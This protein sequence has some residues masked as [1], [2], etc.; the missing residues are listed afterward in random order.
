MRLNYPF[1]VLNR[2]FAALISCVCIFVPL[3]GWSDTVSQPNIIVIICDDLNDSVAGMGGH[4]LAVTPNIQRLI[5]SGV[6]FT[7][8]ASN[9]PVCGP[10]RASVWSGV[11]PINSGIYGADQH[12]NKWYENEYLVN[13]PTLFRHFIDEGYYVRATGKIHHNGHENPYEV[14][15]GYGIGFGSMVNLDDSYGYQKTI[16]IESFTDTNGNGNWDNGEEYTDA[17]G[18]G[19]YDREVYYDGADFGPY[20]HDG[21]ASTP[22]NKGSVPPWWDHPAEADASK[23][24]GVFG[25]YRDLSAYGSNWKWQSPHGQEFTYIDAVDRNTLPYE[26]LLPDE[27]YAHHAVEFIEDYEKVDSNGDHMPFFLTVGFVRPHTPTWAPKK[28]FDMFSI[29]DIRNTLPFDP[30]YNDYDDITGPVNPSTK[31]LDAGTGWYKYNNF[32]SMSEAMGDD[33]MQKIYENIQA[34]LACVAFVD[35]QVGKVLDAVE[36][37]TDPNIKDNTYIIFTSDHG[38]HFGEKEYIFKRTM[39]EESVR[40]PFVVSGPDVVNYTSTRPISLV[41][42][43]PTCVDLAGINNPN[44]TLDGH[45]IKPLLEDSNGTWEGKD[46]SVSAIASTELPEVGTIADYTK[47]HFSIRSDQYRYIRYRD[48]E[49]ELYNHAVDSPERDNVANES[50]HPLLYA[51]NFSQLQT[52]RDYYSVAVGEGFSLVNP[53]KNSNFYFN[54]PI[55]ISTAVLQGISIDHVDFKIGTTLI[56]RDTE[57]P[58]TTTLYDLSSGNYTI[59]AVS[60]NTDYF[61]SSNISVLDPYSNVEMLVDGDFESYSAGSISHTDLEDFSNMGTANLSIVSGDAQSGS[62]YLNVSGRQHAY[63]SIKNLLRGL[64]NGKEYIISVWVRKTENTTGKVQLIRKRQNPTTYVNVHTTNAAGWE[65]LEQ[66]FIKDSDDVNTYISTWPNEEGTLFDIDIDNFSIVEVG[67]AENPLDS[68][69][70]GMPDQW[71]SDHLGGTTAQPLA[72]YD[73]DGIINIF[74]FRAGTLPNDNSSYFGAPSIDESNGAINL[75]WAGSS[76]KKYRIHYKQELKDIEWTVTQGVDL[77]AFTFT[78]GDQG[79]Y[80]VSLD[81]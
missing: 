62:N 75:S 10:S 54:E 15:R 35:E 28:Y 2:F 32:V 40:V 70:D 73:N 33:S 23:P 37:S 46:F 61:D 60:S 59:E 38:F 66:T 55:E 42:L 18:N 53:A 25:Y 45:S 31:D 49:E 1:K 48:G 36:N 52:M 67:G 12:D 13:K 51:Q 9:S 44:Y 77:N 27:K 81:D 11:L 6:Q 74:E 41:D 5:D 7:N 8:A 26:N 58:Y 34:Y 3:L 50:A 24:Y 76:E 20:P 57:S 39:W 80:K 56:K 47:S 4:E 71:E 16:F 30:N 69:H 14:P 43:Y 68:D 78:P 19:S 65:K 79:F 29:E 21:N 22:N 17:N 64:T 72:D 63:A